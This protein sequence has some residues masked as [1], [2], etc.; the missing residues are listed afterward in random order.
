MS[1]AG[2]VRKVL[3]AVK[4]TGNRNLL[5]EALSLLLNGDVT[6][7]GSVP[8]PDSVS[9]TQD[10]LI[11]FIQQ[12]LD[13]IVSAEAWPISI[14]PEISYPSAPST[15]FTDTSSDEDLFPFTEEEE[16]EEEDVSESPEKIYGLPSISINNTPTETTPPIT[17]NPPTESE[18]PMTDPSANQNSPTDH[19]IKKPEATTPPTG[20][21]GL[22]LIMTFFSGGFF[23]TV[24]F[25][26]LVWF[27]EP[28]CQDY[29]KNGYE[30]GYKD[31]QSAEDD[32][33]TAFAQA[34]T[35]ADKDVA[36]AKQTK[37]VWN[38]DDKD[39]KQVEILVSGDA[40]NPWRLACTSKGQTVPIIWD[41]APT[42]AGGNLDSSNCW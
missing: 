27:F 3:N 28:D 21:S 34:A 30:D 26:C 41:C 16:E 22:Y 31:G 36:P 7:M 39:V 37:K 9:R 24:L 6:L 42:A 1:E 35:K 13:N 40:A 20:Y 33:P 25:G 17:A 12:K 32:T 15:Q 10:E 29:Y 38:C 19:S 5:E 14:S 8:C 11:E 23:A 2:K 4:N 18:S